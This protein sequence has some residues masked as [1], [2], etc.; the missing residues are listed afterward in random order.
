M[1]KVSMKLWDTTPGVEGGV[2]PVHYFAP[3][4]EPVSD[5][6]IIAIPG[7]AYRG[8]SQHEGYGYG[9]YFSYKGFHTFSVDYHT[10]PHKFPTQLLEARRAVRWVRAHAAE[11]G[12][13]PH[14]ILV[15]GCSAGGHLVALLSTYTQPI[16]GEGLDEIDNEDYLPDA[17]AL[18]YPVICNPENEELCH[19]ESYRNLIGGRDEA[20]EKALD[21]ALNVSEKTPPAFLFSTAEDA[22]VNVINTYVY[23][24]QLRRH[25][26][27]TEMHIFP[28]GQHGM[29]VWLEDPH[30]CQWS[31]LMIN[32]LRQLGWLKE[33]NNGEN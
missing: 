8:L 22:S 24:T 3:H 32:W 18:C 7:G 33:Q 13:D 16:E 29:G 25:K 2:T 31:G 28:H 4:G 30:N 26:V 10:I 12:I 14:K 27:P 11:Y 9:E 19:A 20:L 6:A 17:H 1:A 5:G 15:I 23:A 21:P